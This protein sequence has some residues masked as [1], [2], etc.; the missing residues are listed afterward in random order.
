[1]EIPDNFHVLMTQGGASQQFSAVPLNLT[2][3]GD[4][5]NFLVSGKWSQ[6]AATEASKFNGVKVVNEPDALL[7]PESWR[8]DKDA[9]FFSFCQNESIDGVSFDQER[10][11]AIIDRV[12]A[13]NPE[14]VIVC[15]MSSAIGSLSLKD[16]WS[17]YGVV[18]AGA[19]KNFGTS[20]LTFTIVRDDVME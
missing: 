17:D 11:R 13:E 9:K 5:V 16:V 10:Q 12:K 8:V 1:M 14:I 15:D 20:G 2:S 6:A 7:S 4:T 3:Q 18:Y 19:Q